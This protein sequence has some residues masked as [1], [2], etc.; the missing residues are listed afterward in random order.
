MSRI[1]DQLGQV[2]PF[3]TASA[4]YLVR[5]GFEIVA[6]SG[7][8]NPEEIIGLHFPIQS[9]NP[10]SEVYETNKTV[11]VAD[12]HAD[13]ERYPHFK[14]PP[15]D[16]IRSWMGV[17][18]IYRGRFIG[19][20]AIDSHK[21]NHFTETYARITSVYADQVAVALETANLVD[22]V[23]Q[24][25]IESE[26]LQQATAAI[27]STFNL[28]EIIDRILEQ[29]KRVI[30]Y[31]TATFLLR[32][33]AG[34]VVH[35]TRGLYPQEQL[36]GLRFPIRGNSVDAEVVRTHQPVILPNVREQHVYYLNP[37][38]ARTITSLMVVPLIL[39]NEVIGEI[40]VDSP[41]ENYFSDEHVRLMTAFAN[42]VVIAIKNAQ[43]YNS[44]QEELQHRKKMEEELRRLATTDALTGCFNRRYFLEL[45]HNEYQRS[46][47]YH[48]P[49]SIIMLD[50]DHFK[51]INDTY[52]HPAGDEV[53]L[54]IVKL[55]QKKIR[56]NDL[57][58]RFGGE[59]FIL[60]LPETSGKDAQVLAERLRKDL[61]NLLVYKEEN[62]FI[63]TTVSM[64]IATLS[65]QRSTPLEKLLKYA[66]E[67]LYYSKE[68]GRNRITFSESC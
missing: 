46:I 37:E 39:E 54:Q 43:L 19:I 31:Q 24:R 59:E 22:H 15:H 16:R 8:S 56:K 25:A 27:A 50:I 21:P 40:G 45:A 4:G 10:S 6:V 2:V 53:L 17:P 44:L 62:I 58:A 7:F 66:D 68:N 26:T 63:H 30:P 35:G 52:G 34:M 29:L 57:L 1:L 9:N 55:C 41:H 13:F 61:E 33:D 38:Y 51:I 47:R 67:A 3:H 11:I 48:H 28:S 14:N 49:L 32:D 65:P 60:L 36:F 23:R 12:T 20:L 5:G 18:L 42:Q 64:G